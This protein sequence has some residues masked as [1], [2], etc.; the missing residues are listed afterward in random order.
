MAM[1]NSLSPK[2]KLFFTPK[3]PTDPNQEFNFLKVISDICGFS[4]YGEGTNRFRYLLFNLFPGFIV[5][6]NSDNTLTLKDKVS[7]GNL[8][9]LLFF[10]LHFLIV[11]LEILMNYFEVLNLGKV[12][13]EEYSSPFNVPA[14]YC[15]G[16]KGD[17]RV[18]IIRFLR[19]VNFDP[20]GVHPYR[21][22]FMSDPKLAPKTYNWIR[23][24]ITSHPRL[25]TGLFSISSIV[26]G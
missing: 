17:N 26:F 18:D 13:P 23:A 11:L 25:K 9:F 14:M 12:L 20:K 6:L 21:G 2:E 24:Q 15:S 5:N 3:T 8:T 10:E 22:V 4:L 19:L 1:W 7:F 16:I